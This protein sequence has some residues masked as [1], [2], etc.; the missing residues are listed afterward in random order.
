MS[1]QWEGELELDSAS[2]YDNVNEEV[3][4]FVAR[5]HAAESGPKDYVSVVRESSLWILVRDCCCPPDVLNLRTAGR[6]WNNA[7]LH[8]EIAALWFFL[9]TKMK[10]FLPP[11]FQSGPACA[12]TIVKTLVSPTA[13]SSQEGCWT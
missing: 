1:P 4:S 3:D 6:R 7:K 2:D 11:Q 13:C 9:T 10:K 12:S 8:G 5:D